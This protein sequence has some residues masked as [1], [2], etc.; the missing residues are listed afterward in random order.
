MSS[1]YTCIRLLVGADSLVWLL[2][3]QCSCLWW[4]SMCGRY[5][6]ESREWKVSNSFRWTEGQDSPQWLWLVTAEGWNRLENKTL[7]SGLVFEF[8]FHSNISLSVLN[9]LILEPVFL[10]SFFT[11]F[12]LLGN[13]LN[14]T[15]LDFTSVI[16]HLLCLQEYIPTSSSMLVSSLMTLIQMMLNEACANP[17]A[18][19]ENRHLRMWLTVRQSYVCRVA[20]ISAACFTLSLCSLARKQLS[21]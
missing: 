2:F 18:A 16:I 5:D 12:K 6:V 17:E 1:E 11:N 19:A 14:L 10:L 9:K 20:S 7:S 4:H 8:S 15:I 21:Q 13:R 3:I